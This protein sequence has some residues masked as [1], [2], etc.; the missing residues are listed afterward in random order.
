VR[1]RAAHIHQARTTERMVDMTEVAAGVHRLT[2]GVANFYVIEESG[3][4]V[5]VDAGAPKDWS[6]FGRLVGE[7]GLE[8]GDLD[9]V[10]LTH[11]HTDHTGFAEQ[12]RAVT[13]ARV[14]VHHDDVAMAQT[15]KVG[16]RDGKTSAYLLRAAFWRTALVLGRRGATKIIPIREVSAF[17]D[18]ERLDVPGKPRV[19]HAPGHTDGSAA[20]VLEDRGIMFTGDV[21]C[22][23]NAYTGRTGPQIMPSGL[24]T[25]T[26]QA[27][28][29]LGNMAGIKA[30]LLLPGHGEPWTGGVEDA[31]RRARTAGPS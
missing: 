8:L 30:G 19:V 23:R 14:W 17:G 12:A 20:I 27:L 21:L 31:I 28:A 29:S 11:A 16:P 3:K 22:T 1:A 18:G 15:G 13:G 2:N 10:L 9:A 6:M 25:D 7:L 4:L 26:P 24:N 5:L